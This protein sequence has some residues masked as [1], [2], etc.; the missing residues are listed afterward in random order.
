MLASDV[1]DGITQRDLADVLGLDPSQVVLLVDELAASGLVE[2]R[3]SDADRRTKLV[4]ATAAGAAM[5]ARAAALIRAAED[6]SLAGLSATE[7][8]I[9]GDLLGRLV[10][11]NG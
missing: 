9:L 11:R 7:R 8:L 5:R 1:P 4:V 6:A 10:S 2:R 3:P